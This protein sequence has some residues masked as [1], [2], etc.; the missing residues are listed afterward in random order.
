[1]E[2]FGLTSGRRPAPIAVGHGGGTAPGDVAPAVCRL[3]EGW[4]GPLLHL[5]PA[6]LDAPPAG[7]DPILIDPADPIGAVEAL[8][9]AAPEVAV[10]FAA[11]GWSALE[12]AY[13]CAAAGVSRR[14]GLD[15][16]EFAGAVLTDRVAPP[17]STRAADRHMALAE[18]AARLM[19]GIGGSDMPRA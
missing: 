14:I 2:H 6:D 16:E 10:L 15:E 19:R 1:M 9:A 4:N 11:P 12:L 7:D 18:A 17:E 5:W 3:S 8:R 13:L